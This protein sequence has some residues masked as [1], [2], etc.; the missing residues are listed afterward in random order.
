MAV[1]FLGSSGRKIAYST[2]NVTRRCQ[3]EPT[4][5]LLLLPGV[6]VQQDVALLGEEGCEVGR[7]RAADEPGEAEGCC[8]DSLTMIDD[9]GDDGAKRDS[10]AAS[11]LDVALRDAHLV[12]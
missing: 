1:R 2:S 8:R 10:P 4:D 12:A 5:D 3:Q 6:Q 7:G 11:A 9:D